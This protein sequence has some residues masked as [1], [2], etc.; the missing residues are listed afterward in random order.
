MK[1]RKHSKLKRHPFVRFIRGI[2]RLF[3]VV[4]RTKKN[5]L[6]SIDDHQNS[7]TV[8]HS[9]SRDTDR[10]IRDRHI[11]AE[12]ERQARDRFITVGEIFDRVQWQIP[13]ETIQANVLET[14]QDSLMYDVSRN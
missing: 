6:R 2:V 4:F 12:A 3:K 11:S 14:S 1:N 9:D 5:N 7:L 8:T 10:L 13:P